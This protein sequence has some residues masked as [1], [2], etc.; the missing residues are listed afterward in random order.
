[1]KGKHSDKDDISVKHYKSFY[2]AAKQLPSDSERLA[3]Y[4]G[5]DR[6]RFEG[7]IPDSDS[8]A[9]KVAFTLAKSRIDA[10]ARASRNG[11]KGGAP[12]GNRNAAKKQPSRSG[13]CS[14][15]TSGEEK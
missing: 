5:I 12:K 6:Y 11:S 8:Y 4:I 9:L 2:E 3:F 7:K 1:M 13:G 15:K 10:D 14:K